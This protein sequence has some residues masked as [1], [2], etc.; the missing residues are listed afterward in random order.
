MPLLILLILMSVLSPTYAQLG[1]KMLGLESA[2]ETSTS[3]LIA[4]RIRLAVVAENV[5]NITTMKVDE[6]GLPYQK[7]YVVLEPYKNGV[8][9]K[10]IEKSQEP[11]LEYNDSYIAEADEKG[12]FKLPNVNLT[13]EMINL[14]YTEVMYEANATCFKTSKT[15]YQTLVDTLK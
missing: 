14:S 8:R 5:A 10:S 7:K 4:Q 15:L 13:E 6:T 12:F 11:F 2:M 9:V 1:R 3:G